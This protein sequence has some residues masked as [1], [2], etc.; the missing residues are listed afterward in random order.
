[1]IT[2]M[3]IKTE[4]S[5]DAFAAKVREMLNIANINQNWHV[6]QQKRDSV[7]HDG[8][9]Y[10]LKVMG[11]IIELLE[12]QGEVLIDD[13]E[14]WPFFVFIKGCQKVL[15]DNEI[16]FIV[17]HIAELLYENDIETH[18]CRY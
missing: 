3:L 9:Y 6:A 1:M 11:F 12:N 15:D 7:N 16:D 13:F 5:L 2:I 18:I 8:V 10:Y 14:E 17:N 4:L